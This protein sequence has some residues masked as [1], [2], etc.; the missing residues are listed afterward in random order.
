VHFA[1]HQE[2]HGHGPSTSRFSIS[3]EVH[4]VDETV[5]DLRRRGVKITLDPHDRPFGRLASIRDPDGNTVYLH[6]WNSREP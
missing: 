3:F 5:A 4:N 2:D 1:I 6:N